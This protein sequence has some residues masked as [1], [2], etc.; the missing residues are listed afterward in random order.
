MQTLKFVLLL[1]VVRPQAFDALPWL[2]VIQVLEVMLSL[3]FAVV[4][5]TV[6]A[7]PLD[8]V[9]RPRFVL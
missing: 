4:I 6:V 7:W 1:S 5:I 2:D 9:W 8:M 3:A